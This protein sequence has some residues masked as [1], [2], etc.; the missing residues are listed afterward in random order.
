MNIK[1]DGSVTIA[2][3]SYNREDFIVD[4]VESALNQIYKNIKVVVLD[5]GSTDKTVELVEKLAKKDNRLSLKKYPN[6]SGSMNRAMK[7]AILE[8]ETEYFTW[9]GSDVDYVSCDLRMVEWG[10]ENKI[11]P[12]CNRSLEQIFPNW[13]GFH[14]VSH[15]AIKPYD[16]VS[17]VR[18]VYQSLCP[19]FP[20]NGMWKTE[21]FAR[22]NVTWIEYK[23]NT[24]SPD[25]LNS[26]LFFSK[27]MKVT[28]YNEFPLIKYHKHP[29]QDTN[30]GI[31]TEQI[32]CDITLIKA[33]FEWF[34][35]I[36]FLGKDCSE[37]QLGIEYLK[38][39]KKL[40]E[41]KLLQF[42]N[43]GDTLKSALSDVSAEAQIYSWE[44][45]SI[46]SKES[47][48]KSLQDFFK[49]YI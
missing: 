49:E 15:N 38:R 25:T 28:H 30:T 17:Y 31:I 7:D 37:S 41:D 23:G 40:I 11:C 18:T 9:I 27:D 10:N 26:L 22:N 33:I 6:N 8:C 24:W 43:G 20:W 5:D 34:Q 3:P 35:P 47:E 32:R 19:P 44:N 29:N 39:L 48:L 21:F 45:F 4:C 46:L 42:P 14:S 12:S 1:K 2:I 13:N 36:D 16:K